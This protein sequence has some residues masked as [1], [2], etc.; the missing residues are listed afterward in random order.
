[1][2]HVYQYRNPRTLR[3]FSDFFIVVL[4]IAYGPHFARM[5]GES[6]YGLHFIVPVLFSIIL[7]SLDNIQN[8]LENPFDQIGE[9]DVTINVRSS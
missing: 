8:H 6:S 9:D 2:K 3:A 5:A 7:V 1:M 4:P